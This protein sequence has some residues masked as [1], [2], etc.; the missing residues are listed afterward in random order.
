MVV[1]M[2]LREHDAIQAEMRNFSLIFLKQNM[3]RTHPTFR[4]MPRRLGPCL[5]GLRQYSDWKCD[6][7]RTHRTCAACPPADTISPYRWSV[8]RGAGARAAA[9]NWPY[10][11]ST[12]TRAG[13]CEER[14]SLLIASCWPNDLIAVSDADRTPW[15]GHLTAGR[16]GGRDHRRVLV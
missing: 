14:I 16:V 5:R 8:G 7:A 1:C 15:G 9:L 10:V 2:R 4:K 11:A 12:R 6:T 3:M 13:W